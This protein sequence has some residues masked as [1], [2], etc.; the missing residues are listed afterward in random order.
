M[1]L[2]KLK[3]I[4]EKQKFSTRGAHENSPGASILCSQTL[5]FS[6]IRQGLGFPCDLGKVNQELSQRAERAYLTS[7][8]G[9]ELTISVLDCR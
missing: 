1:T 8:L 2:Y 3:C 4:S 9:A 5:E 7:Q 6:E